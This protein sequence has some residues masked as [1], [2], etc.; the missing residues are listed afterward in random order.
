MG[1][2]KKRRIYGRKF[3]HIRKNIFA[4]AEIY[5]CAH[6]N[7]P[8][9]ARRH[10]FPAEGV[11]FRSE[12][13]EFS[14]VGKFVFQAWKIFFP[15]Q[16]SFPSSEGKRIALGKKKDRPSEGKT[17]PSEE[18]KNGVRTK[19]NFRAHRNKFSYVRKYFFLRT[20]IYFLTYGNFSPCPQRSFTGRKAEEKR[21]FARL[22]ALP[23]EGQK[24]RAGSAVAKP[25]L[26]RLRRGKGK[27][28]ARREGRE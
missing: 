25:A 21:A 13:G 2:A 17:L 26:L 1:R 11:I 27:A 23:S 15:R 10:F 19:G 16:E 24:E 9:F 20:E 14:K 18:R 6:G 7:F 5:F 3:P 8:P 28:I 12:G 22:D 4:Y